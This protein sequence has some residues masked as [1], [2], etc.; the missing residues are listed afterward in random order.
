VASFARHP[1]A[2]RHARHVNPAF[3]ELLDLLGY[4]RVFTRASGTRMW[5]DEGREYLDAL[6]G[7]GALNLGHNP[8]RIAA[9]LAAFLAAGAP[10]LYHVG[11]SPY[12]GELAEALAARLPEPLRISMFSG[13]GAEAVEAG[14]KLARAATGRGAYISCAGGYHGT[15]LGTLSVMDT[16]RLR[17]PFEP[18]LAN[19]R[20]IAFGDLAAL[21]AALA[22][23]TAAAFVVEPIQAEAGVR[24]PP[25]D[26]LREAAALCRRHG[27]LMIL[28]E[29][30]TGMGRTGTMFAFER[31]GFVPDVLALAKSLGGGIAP[32]GAT[33]TSDEWHARAYGSTQRFDLHG[34]TFGGHSM[35]CVA[36]LETLATIDDEAL[37]AR[38]ESLGARLLA[39]LRARLAGHPLVA[40][41]R[42]QGL[43]VAIEIGPT[44]SGWADRLAPGMV[45]MAAE[46][47]IGQWMAVRLLERGV[48]CQPAA[49]AWNVLKLQPPLVIS[50]VEVDELVAA[51]ASVFESN[52]ELPRVAAG[53]S[54]RLLRRSAARVMS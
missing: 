20:A 51:V 22:A 23:H 7:F 19:C 24:I 46:K 52:R 3:V 14:L 49:G 40:G 21:E 42:G 54:A 31:A 43:L 18:L 9:R 39:A 32:I 16:A 35:G 27:T 53:V 34:S 1:V 12:Q 4:G 10:N 17:E 38:A 25:A 36:A 13:S 5:D 48:V 30:Q 50:E 8:P 28:D 15:N 26:Y 33:I 44:G 29:V 6:A 47:V 2:A 45:A 11:P 37:C 41:V